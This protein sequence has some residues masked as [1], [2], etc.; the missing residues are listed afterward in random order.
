MLNGSKPNFISKTCF[1]LFSSIAL[2]NAA[3]FTIKNITA[4][5]IELNFS[6]DNKY[7]TSQKPEKSLLTF[8]IS[9]QPSIGAFGTIETL[10]GISCPNHTVNTLTSGWMGKDFLQWFSISYKWNSKK[11][12]NPG[13]T[14]KLTYNTPLFKPSPSL[15]INKINNSIIRIPTIHFPEQQSRESLPVLPYRMGVRMSVN[16]DGI[17]ELRGSDLKQLGVPI[18]TIPIKTYRL[19]CREKEV[20][21]YISSPYNSTLTSEDVILF[22]GKFLRGKNSHYTQYSYDNVY[23]LTWD[24]S[25]TGARVADATGWHNIDPNAFTDP[26]VPPLVAWEFTDTLHVEK[27]TDVRWQGDIFTIGETDGLPSKKDIDNWYW[28]FMGDFKLTRFKFPIP[29]P[30]NNTLASVRMLLS[31][32]GLTNINTNPKDHQY[33]LQINNQS[34]NSPDIIWDG[35]NSFEF[36]TNPISNNKLVHGQNT[37]TFSRIQDDTIP[38][39]AAFNWIKII[40]TKGFNALENKLYFRPNKQ[41]INRWTQFNLIGF[42]SQDIEI[43]DIEKYRKFNNIKIKRVANTYSVYFQDSITSNPR[44]FAQA[45]NLR[46]RP[47]QMQLDT[48]KKSWDFPG[49]VDYIVISTDTLLKT[50]QPLIDY[51]SQS[52]IVAPIDIQDIYNSFS[53]GIHDPESIRNMLKYLFS[54]HPKK[55]PRYLLLGGDGSHDMDK[56]DQYKNVIPTHLTRIPNWGPAS[57]DGYFATIKGNDNFQDLSVGRFPARNPKDMEIL[58]NKTLN[59]YRYPENGLWKD[60]IILIG[61]VETD[62]TH[63]NNKAGSKIIGPKMDIIRMDGDP[64][65]PYFTSGSNAADRVAGYI[66]AGAYAVLFAGHGGGNTWSDSKFFSYSDLP[67]LHNSQWGKSGRLP[68]IFSFT[69]LTGFFESTFY[70]SLGEEFLRQSA[71]GCISFYGASGYTRRNIDIKMASTLLTNAMNNDYESLGQ[72]LTTI[73]TMMLVTDGS[74]ALPLIKQYNLLGDP[75]IPWK[76]PTNNLNIILGNNNLKNS[77]TLKITINTSPIMNGSVKIR[78]I[79]DNNISW[80]EII[81]TV[82][83]G[84]VNCILPLKPS[85][86]TAHGIVRAYAWNDSTESKGWI[87]FSKDTITLYD[88]TIS[89]TTPALGDSVRIRCKINM[90][91]S[92]NNTI[93]QCR[94][95]IANSIEG[96]INLSHEVFMQKDTITG[97]WYSKKK[98]TPGSPGDPFDPNRMLILKFFVLGDLGASDYFTFKLKGRPDLTFTSDTI[99]CSWYH[100]SLYIQCEILNKGNIPA[101]PFGLTFL[102]KKDSITDTIYNKIA[103]DSLLP[104][105]SIKYNIALPDTQGNFYYSGF[106]DIEQTIHEIS[107]QNNFCKVLLKASYADIYIP[108]DTLFS[109]SGGMS[110]SPADSLS[111]PC[112]TFIFSYPI[113][114]PMPLV[115]KSE[116]IEL[117]SNTI[118]AFK[119]FSRPAIPETD[120]LHFIFNPKENLTFST[121]S[122]DTT[123]P[124][125]GVFEY[126]KVFS[127]WLNK[128][129]FADTISN[130]FHI[131]AHTTGPL[132]LGKLRDNTPPEIQVFVNGKE[133]LY[134]DYAAKNNPFNIFINDSSGINKSSIQLLHN[135]TPLDF[136]FKS[137][138]ITGQSPAN[139][140]LTAYPLETN[141]IDSLT[142]IAKDNAGNL[143]EKIFAYRPGD[144]LKIN[145]FSCHPNPFVASS[146]PRRLIRFAYLLTNIAEKVTLTIY[147]ISGRKVWQWKSNRQLIG[148]QEIQWDGTTLNLRFDPY[149]TKTNKGFRIANGTYYAK[150]TAS[151]KKRKVK[152]IIRIAKIEG[153]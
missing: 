80:G 54:K 81:K 143:S 64:D 43:W 146:Q 110:L 16:S 103:M 132:A 11:V 19:F 30:M 78:A 136:N 91:D 65:S 44:F 83:A 77:D 49:G 18:N 40:Y 1:F 3:H 14:I 130:T 135:G 48:I 150:L 34:T 10:H 138:I 37:I 112:R 13:G 56:K 8:A 97:F 84:S 50:M 108:K 45:R 72:L 25:Q 32:T 61:G 98:I 133:I 99:T 62:F 149:T 117:S 22:Y 39:R 23:W 70:E 57:D 66:N 100:D 28:G 5:S 24:G 153:Y 47:K 17:Y 67:K 41:K 92:N 131:T 94:Y 46:L 142:V 119:I 151:N 15:L 148:Y 86:Q 79:A 4:N 33:S 125:A 69:C 126:D 102:T 147:T 7:L 106:I 137:S 109:L 58:V 152:K 104:G 96:S 12:T 75:A 141:N 127:Q 120:S 113:E 20:P 88:V 145:F 87:P 53:Y 85:S 124:H 71:N 74:E 76:L 51:H 122:L 36:L 68:I 31:M 29:S 35:Q 93:V 129:G 21:I 52:F 134:L 59:Y 55:P 60:K 82:N 144:D 90:T 89:P 107:E 27:D 2:L 6:I 111:F 140:I 42:T 95:T 123:I 105:A 38:D 118:S 9:S 121:N 73:E 26:S 139:V 116:W 101:P 63:F 114:D 128:G 115:S